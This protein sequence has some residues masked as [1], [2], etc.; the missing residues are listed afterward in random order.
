M[1]HGRLE[2]NGKIEIDPNG[3]TETSGEVKADDVDGEMDDGIDDGDDDNMV[4][5]VE[6]LSISIPAKGSCIHISFTPYNNTRR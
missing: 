2:W 1:G 5:A 3:A 6:I 4:R